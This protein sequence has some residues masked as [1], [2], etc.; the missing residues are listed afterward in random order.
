MNKKVY[1]E[2]GAFNGICGSRS[3]SLS[4]ND[5]YFGILVEPFPESYAECVIN[6]KNN[7]TLI[8]NCAL[9]PFS[10]TS[11]TVEMLISNVHPG[12]NTCAI[13]DVKNLITHTYTNEKVLVSAKT[14]QS[15]LDE[16][17]ITVIDSMFLDVEGSEKNVFDGICH[18]KTFIK[19]LELE[20]HYF[21]TMSLDS[22]IQ[23]HINNLKK[24]NLSFIKTVNECGGHKIYFTHS[25]FIN[26]NP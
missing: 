26:N 15:I 12:M 9:V 3:L 17:N 23:M 22:E 10:Y 19:N 6:R 13:S 2:A 5:D 14:L 24:F 20:L 21:R 7:N 16:N 18:K 11:K 1:I 25:S 4:G 8:Y